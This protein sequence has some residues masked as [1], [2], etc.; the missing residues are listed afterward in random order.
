MV[1]RAS[2]L[3]ITPEPERE[4][5]RVVAT[6]VAGRRPDPGAVASETARIE[7]L[8]LRGS[9]RRWLSYLH[10]VVGLIRQT[11][12]SSDED[13]IHARALAGA[14]I[15]NHHA[16][17]LGLGR[18]PSA[19][20]AIDEAVLTEATKRQREDTYEHNGGAAGHY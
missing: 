2:W 7:R 17:L 6:L 19:Q 13:V 5:P 9:R 16:L 4:L 3:S 18:R 15:A 12:G 20:T 1:K 11:E 8:V 14:V 10:Q